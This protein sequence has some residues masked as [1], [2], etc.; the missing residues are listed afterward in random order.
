MKV[1]RDEL[2]ACLKKV[3]ICDTLHFD[4]RV[5]RSGNLSFQLEAPLPGE[6]DLSCVVDGKPL[7]DMLK[8]M[9][10][11]EVEV[12]LRRG[13]LL[14]T[15][16]G[17]KVDFKL[18]QDAMP[19]TKIPLT[20]APVEIQDLESFV[21]GLRRSAVCVS[22]DEA[23]GSLCGVRIV[24]SKMYACDKFRIFRYSLEEE[25]RLDGSIPLSF[26]KAVQGADLKG[27][28]L[29]L[30][31]RI[32][33]VAADGA[34]ITSSLLAGDYP[35]LARMFPESEAVTVSFKD[36]CIL[37]VLGKH[38]KYQSK[39]DIGAQE[40][41][42]AMTENQCTIVSESN[43]GL[44]Q[45]TVEMDYD[46]GNKEVGFF[47]NPVLFDGVEK[48]CT[49][50]DFYPEDGIVMFTYGQSEYLIRTREEA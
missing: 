30:G 4:G 40:F 23:D 34:M 18:L 27:G 16:G 49:S 28:K 19:L 7:L 1:S 47:A 17:L 15:S 12:V 5:V 14:V 46:I 25:M 50:F 39:V 3:I 32:S 48:E 35:D 44:L 24:G 38:G 43:I 45:E 36:E 41:E 33:F 6:L 21:M 10:G 20:D 22:K 26:I 13:K 42:V 11:D 29:H 2:I 9:N 31:T 8:M 37:G